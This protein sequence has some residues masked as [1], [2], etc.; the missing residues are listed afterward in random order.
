MP[1][2]Q[3][4]DIDLKTRLEDMELLI[5]MDKEVIS[6]Y[7][8]RLKDAEIAHVDKCK[9]CGEKQA[10]WD[11]QIKLK[12]SRIDRLCD[13]TEEQ[14][15]MMRKMQEQMDKMQEQQDRMLAALLTR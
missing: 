6:D 14:R 2:N 5:A 7:R 10:R 1:T 9:E 12:D 11:E 3:N 8:Q 13:H 4:V 15:A